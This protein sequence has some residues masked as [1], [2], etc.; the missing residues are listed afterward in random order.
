MWSTLSLISLLAGIAAVLFAFGNFDLLGWKGRGEHVHPQMLSGQATASQRAT[1][2]FFAVV[3]LLFLVQALAG[4]DV[5]HYRA[6]PGKF[7][8]VDLPA[9]LPSTIMRT[10]HLQLAIFWIATAFVAAD[11]FWPALGARNRADRYG[12]STCSGGAL[13]LVVAG[14]LIGELV[15]MKQLA[16]KLWFWF[17]H[18]GWEYLELGRGW[19]VLLASA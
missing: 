19:Q 15:G 3:A 8:G 11:C 9:L 4:G 10:W 17:G 16:G 6:Q 13:V 14:S 7:Y 18:Q 5:A 12:A 1:L 2:K